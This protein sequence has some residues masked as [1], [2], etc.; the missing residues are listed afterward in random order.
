MPSIARSSGAVGPPD[1]ANVYSNNSHSLGPRKIVTFFVFVLAL[2]GGVLWQLRSGL[3]QDPDAYREIAENVLQHGVF[4]LTRRDHPSSSRIV[5][6][7]AYRPVLYPLFL[8]SLHATGTDPASLA[9]IAAAHLLLGG[10]TVAL[11][12]FCAWRYCGLP[13]SQALAA[14]LVVACDP[15]LL[16]QQ[17]LVMTETLATFLAILALTGL[18]HWS[19]RP[20]LGSAA[21][22]GVALGL[23]SLCRPTFLPWL[24]AAAVAM[25]IL[26]T[27]LAAGE[28]ESKGQQPKGRAPKVRRLAHAVVLLLA[29]LGVMLPWAI[30]NTWLFGRPILT[31]THGGYTLELGNNPQFYDWLFS[32]EELPWDSHP[33]QVQRQAAMSQLQVDGP[34][35]LFWDRWAYQ[36]AWQTMA[37]QPW[38]LVGACLYRV[39]QLWSPLPHRLTREE[40]VA[41][42]VGRWAVASWYCTVYLFAAYGLTRLGR[43]L[44]GP[45]WLWGL[46]LVAIWTCIHTLYWTNLRM[47]AP[48]IP[49][50][51]LLAGEGA[52]LA[53]AILRAGRRAL[54]VGLGW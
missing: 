7:T 34:A 44:V 19:W 14:S 31:T 27:S 1:M 49:F 16:H 23:A 10:L 15:I 4:G 17:S 54:W 36:R 30:R 18:A 48:L 8:V 21:L 35:E 5:V 43:K 33:W 53:S 29:G 42:Q 51:A 28:I 41:R 22:A 26:P 11:T 40:P 9:K 24:M 3:Q 12:W 45:P 50:V 38:G 20:G 6:P 39:G 37:Q 47:R 52:G 32:D 13:Q 46:M 25:S 2:R